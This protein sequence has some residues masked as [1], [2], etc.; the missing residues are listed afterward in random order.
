MVATIAY[1]DCFSGIS[2]DM[3]LG[4]FLGA[5]LSLDTLKDGLAGLPLTGYQL[6]LEPF[7]DKGIQGMRF[8]VLV[9][10]E[11]QP[12]RHL[13]DIVALLSASGLS[14]R[15][16]NMALAVFGCLAE[17]E[18]AV[19]GT[20]VEAV[21]FHEVGAVDAI[22]DICGAAIAI[23][24]LAI[25]QVYASPLPLT[26]GEVKTAHGVLP[27]PAPATM[28]IL[29][30]VRAPWRPSTAQGELVTPT[31]AAILATLARF[32]TPAIA[33][34]QVGYGFGRKQF[35]WPNCLRLCLG[36]ALG[37]SS[38]NTSTEVPDT[39]WV[40]VIESN[41]DNMSGEELGGL[42][43]RML[44]AGAYDVS[45]IP[46]QMKK[47]RPAVQVTIICA[48][49]EGDA[50]ARLLLSESS[51]LGVRVQQVQRL[52]A[53]RSSERVE[54]PFGPMLVKV[55][56]LGR[57]V[58]SVAPEFEECRRVAEEQHLP[59]GEVYEIAR[60]AIDMTIMSRENK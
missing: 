29:R 17:A 22:I 39:D 32:E 11:E 35:D 23:E 59:L 31:G 9:A 30:R 34:S 5:G 44:A 16:L 50:M 27:V 18:A 60:Q 15:V 28:E 7:Q 10:Q 57:R 56:R 53:Q 14:P 46:L 36:E 20:T 26:H 41:I 45:Y 8:D 33:I 6:G 43:E 25:T 48:L 19:H 4:A 37:A 2:G 52:K 1:L 49:Q 12:V 47:N 51:T 58:L 55:K 38:G 42:M 54:T 3:L 13:S 40:T 21:H 24:A